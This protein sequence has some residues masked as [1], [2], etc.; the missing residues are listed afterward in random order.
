MAL[1]PLSPSTS[2]L[3]REPVQKA[4]LPNQ[5]SLA[6]PL[7]SPSPTSTLQRRWSQAQAKDFHDLHTTM[8]TMVLNCNI[9]GQ[10]A[11]DRA[12][13]MPS[14]V[15]VALFGHSAPFYMQVNVMQSISFSTVSLILKRCSGIGARLLSHDQS[16]RHITHST[17]AL[18]HFQREPQL[19]TCP[20]ARIFGNFQH[21]SVSRSC[22]VF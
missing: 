13:A 19:F 16:L 14:E 9:E 3:P 18:V 11:K 10:M 2:S 5:K 12:I 17:N 4:I 7:P 1:R 20:P 15:H 8:A 21:H 6:I 22:S